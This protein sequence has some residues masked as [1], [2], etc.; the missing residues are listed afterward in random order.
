[1]E[2]IMQGFMD[3]VKNNSANTQNISAMTEEQLASMMNLEESLE[4]ILK[5][6]RHLREDIGKFKTDNEIK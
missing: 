6:S 1:M 5:S 3:K 4:V 2:Q